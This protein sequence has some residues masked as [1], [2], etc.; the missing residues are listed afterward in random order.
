MQKLYKILNEIYNQIYIEQVKNSHL[1]CPYFGNNI[2]QS[3]D[4]F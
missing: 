2:S 4:T 1:N 3:S